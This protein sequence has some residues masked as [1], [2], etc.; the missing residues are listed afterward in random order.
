MDIIGA[1]FLCLKTHEVFERFARPYSDEWALNE[2]GLKN[3]SLKY[4]NDA[5]KRGEARV[6]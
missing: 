3:F 4:K 1:V 2:S 5:K 6:Y